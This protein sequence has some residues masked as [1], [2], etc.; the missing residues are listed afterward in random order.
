ENHHCRAVERCGGGGG[1]V[2]GRGRRPA[3]GQEA[4]RPEPRGEHEVPALLGLAGP[5]PRLVRSSVVEHRRS[6]AIAPCAGEEGRPA[7]QEPGGPD[8]AVTSPRR[9]SAAVE[10][11]GRAPGPTLVVAEKL[12]SGPITPED[13]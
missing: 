7:L 10:R 3:P 5:R 6:H 11:R 2:V 8:L 12:A 4:N 13:S 9:R 1:D